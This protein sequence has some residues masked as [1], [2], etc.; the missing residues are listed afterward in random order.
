ML[1]FEEFGKRFHVNIPPTNGDEQKNFEDNPDD[2]DGREPE[3]SG[4]FTPPAWLLFLYSV[5]VLLLILFPILTLCLP[6]CLCFPCCCG[7]YR[8]SELLEE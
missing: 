5:L 1:E 7:E 6:L 2:D 4:K 8:D 3:R